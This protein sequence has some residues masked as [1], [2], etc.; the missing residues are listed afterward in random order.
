MAISQLIVSN[1]CADQLDLS[2]FNYRAAVWADIEHMHDLAHRQKKNMHMAHI[3]HQRAQT[4]RSNINTHDHKETWAHIK[5]MQALSPCHYIKPLLGAHGCPLAPH[6][7]NIRYGFATMCIIVYFLQLKHMPASR[8]DLTGESV[9]LSSSIGG[10][11]ACTY[12]L[13]VYI[14]VVSPGTSLHLLLFAA[15]C[16]QSEVHDIHCIVGPMMM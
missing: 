12:V 16:F 5:P 3:C 8:S 2:L 15:V 4:W 7:S 1:S 6:A 14:Y 10:I 13:P 11:R 9:R